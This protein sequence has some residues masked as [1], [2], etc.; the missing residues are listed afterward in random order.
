MQAATL[1]KDYVDVP[2]VDATPEN[3][4]AYGLMIGDSVH[5]PGLSI[6]FYKGSVEE[7]ENLDFVYNERAVV[8]TALGADLA[9]MGS[10]AFSHAEGL[11]WGPIAAE[12]AELYRSR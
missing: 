3:T 7:G 12:T 6:P 4:A 8:R 2:L 11:A 1:E 10:R 5:R 9:A